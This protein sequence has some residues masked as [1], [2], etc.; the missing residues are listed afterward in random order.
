MGSTARND[1]RR[2][3]ILERLAKAW[4]K[5]PAFRLGELVFMSLSNAQIINLMFLDDSEIVEAIER[6]VL[7][8]GNQSGPPPAQGT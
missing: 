3:L 5:V 4:D 8:N 2:A 1:N 6:Y 7:T